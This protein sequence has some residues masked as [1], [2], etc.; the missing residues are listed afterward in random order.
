MRGRNNNNNNN[1]NNNRRG[2]N[3]LTRSYE[4]NGPDVKIRGSAQQ[5]AEKYTALARDAQSSGDRVMAGHLILVY[6][7]TTLRQSRPVVIFDP[8]EDDEEVITSSSTVITNLEGAI[9][10]DKSVDPQGAASSQ[11]SALVRAGNELA[12]HRPLPELALHVLRQSIEPAAEKP[13]QRPDR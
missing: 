5:I 13:A 4:S 3:P 2:P 11:V 8:N 9:R 7:S 12:G 1:N 6:D 10:T